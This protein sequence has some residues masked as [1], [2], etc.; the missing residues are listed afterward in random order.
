MMLAIRTNL[1]QA[2]TTLNILWVRSEAHFADSPCTK[3][4]DKDGQ[5]STL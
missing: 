4:T 2:N 3:Y 5:P 1:E